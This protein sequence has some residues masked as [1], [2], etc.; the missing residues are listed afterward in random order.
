MFTKQKRD[1]AQP[2]KSSLISVSMQCGKKNFKKN[3]VSKFAKYLRN[4]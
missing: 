2:E 1:V 3:P 4:E